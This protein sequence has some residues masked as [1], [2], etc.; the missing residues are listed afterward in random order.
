MSNLYWRSMPCYPDGMFVKKLRAVMFDLDGTLVDTMGAFADLAAAVM[1]EQHGDDGVTARRRYMETSGIPFHQQLEV[2]HPGHASNHTASEDF[3]QR[4]RIVCD[5]TVM[6]AATVAGL[7]EL[8][9]LGYKLIVS[10]NASQRFVDEFAARE[11]FKFELSL[12]FDAARSLAKG[13]PHVELTCRQLGLEPSDIVFCGDS[14]KDAE[15]AMVCEV[16]FVGRLGTFTH[17]DFCRIDPELS[18]VPH[19]VE[20]P[21]L[22]RS[23]VAA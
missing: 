20:L 3:E 2:I 6:D 9:G 14:L 17:A 7:T 11:S 12:G 1:V 5:E 23:R 18:T 22:L 10:S 21:G 19:V 13:R 8:R 16:A 15:L 4:K